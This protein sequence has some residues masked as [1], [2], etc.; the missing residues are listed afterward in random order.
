MAFADDVVLV[1]AAAGLS[2]P[3]RPDG[4]KAAMRRIGALAYEAAHARRAA[5]LGA[6][7]YTCRGR[8]S[9]ARSTCS[10]ATEAFS[11]AGGPAAGGRAGAAAR[12]PAAAP[13]RACKPPGRPLQMP[14]RLVRFVHLGTVSV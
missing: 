13:A 7:G 2:G 3:P 6:G 4:D 8:C 1:L 9:T 10:T 5:G 11:S 14:Q 12:C